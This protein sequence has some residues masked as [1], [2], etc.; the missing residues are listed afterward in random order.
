[1]KHALSA[2]TVAFI[3]GVALAQSVPLSTYYRRSG[4]A[5]LTGA[6][7]FNGTQTFPDGIVV[8]IRDGGSSIA[9]TGTFTP[10][11]NIVFGAS[12]TYTIGTG[13]NG[14]AAAHIYTHSLTLD[15]VRNSSGQQIIGTLAGA[16]AGLQVRGDDS[17]GATAIGVT[18]D[19][20]NALSTAGALIASFQNA[21]T[22]K[23]TVDLNGS[24]TLVGNPTLQT[25]AA[26][27]EGQLSR[28]VLSGVATGKRT[29][30]CLCTSDG[31]SAY[32]W[33]NVV[34]GT[35][36]TTTTCGTE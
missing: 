2:F 4:G 11:G 31:S 19:N 25:C 12:N 9:S 20:R 27:I 29:K 13:Y 15:T 28:D 34:T 3:G 1:M 21:G 7:S 16:G 6:N 26:G 36:G 24:Y 5:S 10:T 14:G 35:L 32:K 30:L 17:N 22:T 33:Q 8:S 18:I 23:A